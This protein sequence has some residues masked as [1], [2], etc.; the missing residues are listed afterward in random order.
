VSLAAAPPHGMGRAVVIGMWEL[1]H[2]REETRGVCGCGGY[3]IENTVQ[4]GK[5]ERA[6]SSSWSKRRIHLLRRCRG[7]GPDDKPLVS[8]PDGPSGG[9]RSLE[10]RPVYDSLKPCSANLAAVARQAASPRDW[11]GENTRAR[12]RT[13]GRTDD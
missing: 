1:P 9:F 10:R 5:L 3:Y 13:V 8:G 11:G 4:I 7:Y 2:Q 12:V 6:E